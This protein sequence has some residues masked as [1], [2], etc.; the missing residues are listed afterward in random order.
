MFICH[1]LFLIF[2]SCK[3]EKNQ[4]GNKENG[5]QY[6]NGKPKDIAKKGGHL[7]AALLSD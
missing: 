2:L 4:P 5:Q 7:Y 1:H 6:G 3:G